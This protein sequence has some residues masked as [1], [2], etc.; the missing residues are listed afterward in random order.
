MPIGLLFL[1]GVAVLWPGLK[2]GSGGGNGVA[3]AYGWGGNM[4]LLALVLLWH[5]GGTI[6]GF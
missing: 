1:D 2:A 6:F 5:P 4:L 3:W